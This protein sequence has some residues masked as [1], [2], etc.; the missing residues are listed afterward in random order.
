MRLLTTILIAGL[1]TACAADPA[2]V[3]QVAENEAARLE[4]P[5]KLLSSFAVFELDEMTFSAEIQQEEKKMKEAREFED[6]F[7]AKVTPLLDGWNAAPPDGADGTLLIQVHLD[8]LHIVSGG[9]RFWIGAWAGDSFIEIDLQLID[10]ATN[11]VIADV[12]IRRDANSMTGAWSVGKSD[13][14][15]DEY[16]V[17]IVHEYLSDSYL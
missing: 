17:S 9:S 12:P 5:T 6:N 13:Q 14:N 11:E 2:K 1:L 15:L 16:V 10:G 7:N 3:Q 4:T 8:R